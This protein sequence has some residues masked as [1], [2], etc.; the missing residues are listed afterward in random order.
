[1]QY[2]AAV[3]NCCLQKPFLWAG[4]I[5]AFAKTLD[6]ELSNGKLS[7]FANFKVKIKYSKNSGFDLSLI[8]YS[9]LWYGHSLGT[10]GL[11]GYVCYVKLASLLGWISF[12]VF[13]SR[14]SFVLVTQYALFDTMGKILSSKKP[15]LFNKS[16]SLRY[17]A[18]NSPSFG[19]EI[20]LFT[21]AFMTCKGCNR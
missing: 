5:I 9:Y 20:I 7:T 6:K 13:I 10:I 21:G 19:I 15:W 1:M 12:C 14:W 4:A 18:S 8:V 17:R 16:H 2:L 11:T 3:C